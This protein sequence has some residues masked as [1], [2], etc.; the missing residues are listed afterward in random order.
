MT[1]FRVHPKRPGY[2]IEMIR[3]NGTSAVVWKSETEAEALMLVRELEQI[4][5]VKR[6]PSRRLASLFRRRG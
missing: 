4:F 2:S 6:N 3:L 5:A 1:T